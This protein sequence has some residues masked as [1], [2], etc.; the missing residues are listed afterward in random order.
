MGRSRGRTL[1]GIALACSAL[2]SV[3]VPAAVDVP[4]HPLAGVLRGP[5]P[6]AAGAAVDEVMRPLAEGGTVPL[7]GSRTD[8]GVWISEVAGFGMD[9]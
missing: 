5:A 8:G 9:V 2:V 4:V 1:G 7:D 6:E 3:P